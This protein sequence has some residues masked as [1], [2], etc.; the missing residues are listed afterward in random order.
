MMENEEVI[1][2]FGPRNALNGVSGDRAANGQCISCLDSDVTQRF[3]E[4]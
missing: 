4:R 2:T 3:N 1:A